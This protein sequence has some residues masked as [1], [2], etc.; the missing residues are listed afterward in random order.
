MQYVVILL[1]LL[2][3]GVGYYIVQ[4]RKQ[5]TQAILCALLAVM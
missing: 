2:A 5:A 3:L 4:K 1:V